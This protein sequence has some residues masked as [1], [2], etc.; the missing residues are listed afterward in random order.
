MYRTREEETEKRRAEEKRK[1]EQ[2][3][4]DYLR[5][6]ESANCSSGGAG[7]SSSS[8]QSG[9]AA[10]SVAGAFAEARRRSRAVVPASASREREQQ[11]QPPPRPKSMLVVDRPPL[12]AALGGGSAARVGTGA[13][14]IALD[15]QT[16]G[17]GVARLLRAAGSSTR[18][19]LIGSSRGHSVEALARTDSFAGAEPGVFCFA[20]SNN[21]SLVL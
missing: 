5:K 10:V 12:P 17:G 8:A 9:A 7:A 16:A 19:D 15:A 20:G 14:G 4:A 13:D 1:R 11:Q 2:I 6:K 21:A 3:Y 18:L